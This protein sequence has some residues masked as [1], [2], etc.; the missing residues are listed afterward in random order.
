MKRHLST[1]LLILIFFA[2]LSVLLYPTISDF[3]NSKTQSRAIAEYVEAMSHIDRETYDTLLEQAEDYNA[4]LIAN[5]GRFLPSDEERVAFGA[6]LG[7][8]GGAVGYIE[9]GVIGVNLPI[10]LGDSE[11]ILQ[12]GVGALPGASI[13]VGGE[14]THSVLTGHR[15]LPSAKL[16][17]NLDQLGLGDTFVLFV[18]NETLTY[19]VDQIRIVL[20]EELSGLAIT[21]GADLCTLVTCTPYGINSHRL[22]I[23]GHRVENAANTGGLSG[24]VT[25]DAL[26][27]DTLLV[28]PIVAAPMLLILMGVLLFRGSAGH[29][30]PKKEKPSRPKGRGL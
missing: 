14:G 27:V 22:L 15:G 4:A 9:I 8:T 24:R 12:V 16:F 18:L 19:E 21:P 7:S 20:P 6:M 10:Y 3:V 11:A 17:T 25:A 5:P 26:Q 13:P 30:P 23:R 28:T 29:K 2:G 1:I